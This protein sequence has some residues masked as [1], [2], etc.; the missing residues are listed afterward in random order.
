M[1]QEPRICCEKAWQFAAVLASIPKFIEKVYNKKRL[2]SVLG[3]PPPVK[4]EAQLKAQNMDA[5]ARQLV[6]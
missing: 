5:A 1:L 6:A 2:H 4:F 3:N